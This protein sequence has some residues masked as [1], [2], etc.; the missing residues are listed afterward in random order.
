VQDA[1]IDQ[2]N[3]TQ[4]K[5]TDVT[6]RVNPVSGTLRRSLVKF[7]LSSIP[8]VACVNSA[9]LRLTLAAVQSPE[10]TFAVHRLTQS[11][12]EGAPGSIIII[13]ST[14]GAS[15]SRRDG[16]NSWTAPGGDFVATA[17]ATVPTGTTNNVTLQWDVTADVRAFV[18]GTAP[19]Q[20][21]LVKDSHEG[22]GKEFQLVSREA[23]ITGNRPQLQITFAPCP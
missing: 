16:V 8:A 10:Q 18:G 17:T 13:G 2:A 14:N 5:G 4:N 3:P 12:T 20:G 11:W 15:W 9:T 22:A 19:N 7:D 23:T 21:W 6:L 1:W